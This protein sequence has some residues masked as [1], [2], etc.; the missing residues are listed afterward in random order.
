MISKHRSD[1]E[2]ARVRTTLL[3]VLGVDPQTLW[4]WTQGTRR[5]LGH[6]RDAIR[7]VTGINPS[8]WMDAAERA[9]ALRAKRSAA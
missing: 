3:S 8:E 6:H 4:T 5:P 1:A 7:C 2:A 9:V